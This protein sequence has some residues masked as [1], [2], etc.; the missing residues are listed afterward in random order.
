MAESVPPVVVDASVVVKW[1]LVA[2]E[3]GVSDAA[4]LLVEHAEG[5]VRL[6]APALLA[7]ELMGVFVRRIDGEGVSRGLD[8]FFDTGVYLVPPDRELMLSAAELA[9][10]HQL[11]A[12]DSAYAALATSLGCSLA[13]A[14]RRLADVLGS[15]VQIR[16][17]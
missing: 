11:S 17:V 6:V 2:G 8:A 14:D 5:R 10:R 9:M 15:A 12:F 7:H 3:S 16:A 1:F 4:A 13:T